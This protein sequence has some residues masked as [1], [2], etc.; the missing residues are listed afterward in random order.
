MRRR[1]LPS[2]ALAAVTVATLAAAPGAHAE[3]EAAGVRTVKV[4]SFDGTQI[5]TNFF[6]AANLP[7]GVT[8]PTVLLGH[9]WGGRAETDPAGGQ[10]GPLRAAGYNVVTWNA[11]G[12]GSEG[13]ANVDEPRVEGRDTMKLIDWIAR[14]PETQLDGP[15]DPRLGMAGGSYGGAIQLV[16]AG[17]D[18][19]VDVIVPV[20]AF[21]NLER[22]LYR[23][24][25]YRSGWGLILCTSGISNGN[26]I[27]PQV[28]AGCVAGLAAGQLPAALRKWFADHGPD[29]LVRK[30]KIPTLVVQGT[31]DTLF[32]LREGIATYQAIKGNG[33]PVKMIWFCGGHGQCTTNPGAPDHVM[34]ATLTWFDRYLKRNPAAGTGPEFEY[35]DQD[36]A[37]HGAPAYP[38][39]ALSPLKATGAGSLAFSRLD[40]GEFVQATPKDWTLPF[41]PSTMMAKPSAKAVNVPIPAPASPGQTVGVPRVTLTYK[42]TAVPARTALFAQIVDQGTGTVIGNQATPLPV[43]LDGRSH[44]LTRDLEAI[45]WN[46]T[47]ASRLVLQIVPIT[48]LFDWQ[49]SAGLV[50]LQASVSLPR[51]RPGTALAG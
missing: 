16:T 27:A 41:L 39:P 2:A 8:A 21:N 20:I 46:V 43:T 37:Y 13:A 32:P 38:Q 11:R 47:P 51:V 29:Q 9:G 49:R 4:A 44:S 5:L 12:F 23:D 45:S 50:N 33:A 28:Q 6:P 19:R 25:V 34:K 7:A 35:I 1:S 14:Q 36:G 17:L 3:A 42:G 24:E 26:K 31:V 48:G 30:I 15:G 40:A 10:V 22:T 18:K